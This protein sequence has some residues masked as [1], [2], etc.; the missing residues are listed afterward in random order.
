VATRFDRLRQWQLLGRFAELAGLDRPSAATVLRFLAD[1]TGTSPVEAAVV[2][3]R[4]MELADADPPNTQAVLDQTVRLV[5]GGVLRF[6]VS[7]RPLCDSCHPA[8][9]R[10]LALATLENMRPDVFNELCASR[11]A[12]RNVSARSHLTPVPPAR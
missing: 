5:A 11:A 6:P 12:G 1:E 9:A 8:Q 2:A 7:G 4:V 10:R 3:T